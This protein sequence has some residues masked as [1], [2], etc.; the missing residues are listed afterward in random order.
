MH[1]YLNLL[2]KRFGELKVIEFI[3]PAKNRTI[4]WRCVC[5]CGNET[6]V[7][8]NH[9]VHEHTKSCGCLHRKLISDKHSLNLIGKR[10]G[11]LLIIKRL[12]KKLNST[13][14]SVWKCICDC[15]NIVEHTASALINNKVKSCGCLYYEQCCVKN[16]LVDPLYC[17]EFSFK[18]FKIMIKQRDKFKCMNP[19][20]NFKFNDRL[21]IHHIDYNKKNCN[22]N[23]LIT[24]C[25][26]CNAKANYNR[27]WHKSWYQAIMFKRYGN[28]Y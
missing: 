9:L 27:D 15:G 22:L 17:K 6:I 11:R 19:D 3:G 25:R 4:L 21:V 23:N 1:K 24:V 28:I 5:N 20:C 13:R 16:G 12:Y 18:E 7:R 26:S 8:A 14:C 10:F 2:G